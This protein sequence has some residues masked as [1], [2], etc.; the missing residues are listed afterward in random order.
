[1]KI[2]YGEYIWNHHEKCIESANMSG[3]GL[4]IP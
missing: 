1:M 3:I 4:E 2:K